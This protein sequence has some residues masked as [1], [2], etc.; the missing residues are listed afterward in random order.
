MN[1]LII[2]MWDVSDVTKTVTYKNFSRIFKSLD[3]HPIFCLYN[4]KSMNQIIKNNDISGIIIGGSK[5]RILSE[6]SMD[7]PN[8]IFQKNLPILGICYGFQ[9][10]MKKFGD[11]SL[12]CSLEK[13]TQYSKFI[14]I[15]IGRFKVPKLR[16]L[17][18]YND[19]VTKVPSKWMIDVING[20]EVCVAH[21]KKNIGVQ[22]HPEIYGKSSRIF[23]KKW[24]D[25]IREN[26]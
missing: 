2:V 7:L 22:F 20:N 14:E 3:V 6:N 15:E 4:D 11:K 24:I 1:V 9:L 18:R 23:F 13:Q 21:Y 26:N 10:M 5:A 8:I 17:F 19:Y 16:Y 25:F 12:F